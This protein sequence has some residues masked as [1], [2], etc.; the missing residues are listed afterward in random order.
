[1]Y[2]GVSVYCTNVECT[3]CGVVYAVP[4]DNHPC[5]LC[6]NPMRK[7]EKASAPFNDVQK[8]TEETQR[9]VWLECKPIDC[10]I[11]L[12]VLASSNLVHHINVTPVA[13]QVMSIHEHDINLLAVKLKTKQQLKDE[14]ELA[15]RDKH[16]CEMVD[17]LYG[18]VCEE[19]N[20]A[21]AERASLKIKLEAIEAKEKDRQ[22][23]NPMYSRAKV[24]CCDVCGW[25]KS[26]CVC[27]TSS[28]FTG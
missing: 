5:N 3:D 8:V 11:I 23:D 16:N 15:N 24:S 7:V 6:G 9:T 26:E 27:P 17:T 2:Y 1:M 13:V 18:K 28:S 20:E 12:H 25:V 10:D 21:Y 19:R 4:A 14:D 22:S